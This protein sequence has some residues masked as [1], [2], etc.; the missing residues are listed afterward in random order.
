MNP[1]ILGMDGLL[2]H[3]ELV[4]QLSD[5][6]R[7]DDCEEAIQA[8]VALLEHLC[9]RVVQGSLNQLS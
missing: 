2:W 4:A 9:D 1:K 6:E 8:I 5:D 7:M 3:V